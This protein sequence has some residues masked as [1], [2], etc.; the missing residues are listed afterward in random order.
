MAINPKNFYNELINHGIEFFTGVPD[1]LLKELCLCIDDNISKDRHVITA[2]EGNAVALAAGYYLANKSIPLVY[3]QNS[4]LGNAV[5]PFLSLCNPDVYSIPML[6]IVGWRGEPGIKDEPQH[7]KQGEVQLELL[8]A[9]DIPYVV[10]SKADHQFQIKIASMIETAKNENKPVAILIKKGTFNKFEKQN[11]I[12]NVGM[13]REEALE[14]I[15]KNLDG[16]TTV[17]STTG[18]T[19]R[20]IFEI[21]EKTN[22]SHQQDFLTV[23]SMGHCSSIALGIALAKPDLEVVCIDGDGAMLM[24]LGNLVLI[25]SLKPNN[26]RHIL[27]NN[28]VHDSVGGQD[29][30]AKGI[31]LSPV[32]ES[33]GAI[34]VF[35]VETPSDLTSQFSEFIG[36]PGP[37]FLEIKISPGSRR[38]LGRPTIEPIDNKKD[39][40]KILNK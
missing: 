17:V 2:N 28:G 26:F 37:S 23:G 31:S 7:K 10:I 39:F 24:H 25:A 9:I 15:L 8:E 38:S 3:M 4:G 27:L 5:N 1:S 22:H 32:V 35:K 21:R 6:V 40:M 11:Q 36:C 34:K 16:N 33:L 14:L 18:K 29:T 12:N 13:L 20:E 30:A 19:S